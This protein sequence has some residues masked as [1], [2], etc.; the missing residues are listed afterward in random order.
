ML[1]AATTGL[2]AG[3]QAGY[4]LALHVDDLSPPVDPETTVRI[5]PDRIECRRVEWRFFDPVHGR[6]GPATELGIATLVHERVPLGHRF[7]QVS[8]WNSLELMTA[9]DLRGQLLD[10]IGAE[11]EP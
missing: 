2:P 4:R 8:K 3:I 5:V 6:I 10:R 1:I 11:E 7:H 9:V